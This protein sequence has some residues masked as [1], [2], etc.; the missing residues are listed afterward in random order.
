MTTTVSLIS[1]DVGS[2]AGG[3]TVLIGGTGFTGAT[4]VQFWG[5]NATS[6]TVNSD[7]EIHAT[8][9]PMPAPLAPPPNAQS[10]TVTVGGSQYDGPYFTWVAAAPVIAWV[11]ITATVASISPTSGDY[12]GGQ[13]MTITGT[14]FTNTV[15]VDFS[16]GNTWYPA[17]FT[18]ESDTEITATVPAIG[19]G[20][21][22]GYD[23][24]VTVTTGAG[25][26]P[27]GLNCT[28]IYNPA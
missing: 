5:Q 27:T 25:V 2:C 24:F 21:A 8:T 12:P 18:I 14:G 17:S 23:F 19:A 13:T 26:S 3:E 11:S 4:A 9:P 1:P 15:E 7:T 20:F 22:Y 6:F 28:F 10:I 16:I